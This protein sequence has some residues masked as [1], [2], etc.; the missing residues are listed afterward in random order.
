MSAPNDSTF[1]LP[2]PRRPGLD[3][4]NGAAKQNAYDKPVSDPVRMPSAE[5]YNTLCK[6]AV[7]LGKVVPIASVYVT[8]P[9]GDPTITG[10]VGAGSSVTLGTFTPT[11][12]GAGNTTIAWSTAALPVSTTPPSLTL[13][14]DV[15]IDRARAWRTYPSAGVSAV[16]V[17]TKL[18]ATGTDCAFKID[19][20]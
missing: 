18:G 2:T 13:V 19:I 8:F 16:Q 14:E 5:E 15:E 17:K 7:A 4:F 10:V 6:L 3:D 1:D 20:F 9:G 11:D 12:N